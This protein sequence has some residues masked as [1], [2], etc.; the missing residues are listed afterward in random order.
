MAQKKIQYLLPIEHVSRKFTQ[1]ANTCGTKNKMTGG[2]PANWLGA[3]VLTKA[4]KEFY[5]GTKR[6]Y[7][8]VRTRVRSTPLTAD[9]QAARVRFVAV[10]EMV[11]ARKTDLSKITEDQENFVKQYNTANGVRSMNAY[12]WKICGAEYDAQ[13]S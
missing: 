2:M 9:E 8:V 4:T 10:K 6:N 1:V 11:Q 5:P 7:F 12:L 13:H 3:G